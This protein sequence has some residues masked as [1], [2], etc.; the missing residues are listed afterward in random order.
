MRRSCRSLILATTVIFGASF[1]GDGVFSKTEA[2]PF[3][4]IDS[5]ILFVI[6]GFGVD[7]L[8]LLSAYSK[9]VFGHEAALVEMMNDGE[10]GLVN[11][12][13]YDT[14]VTDAAAAAT[15]MATGE[16]TRNGFVGKDPSG[17]DLES[18]LNI[19]IRMKKS[20][21]L[22]TDLSVTGP[23]PAG[24]YANAFSVYDESQMAYLLT[25]KIGINLILGGGMAYFLPKGSHTDRLTD[26]GAAFGGASLRGDKNNLW[27]K[28]GERGCFLVSDSA[29]LG[30]IPKAAP[31]VCGFFAAAELPYHVDREGYAKK[32]LPPTLLELAKTAWMILSR[33]PRGFFFLVEAGLVGYASHENDIGTVLQELIEIDR[34]VQFLKGEVAGQKEKRVLFLVTSTQQ[35]GGPA[36]AYKNSFVPGVTKITPSL[37]YEAPF[38][39]ISVETLKKI[40]AQKASLRAILKNARGDVAKLKNLLKRDTGFDVP[41]DKLKIIFSPSSRVRD[42][43]FFYVYD[44]DVAVVQ[45]ARVLAEYSGV[46]WT[47]GTHLS[48]FVPVAAYG[49]D[50][51]HFRGVMDNTKIGLVVNKGYHGI[52][53]IQ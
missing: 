7:H 29:K 44:E 45:L 49:L 43:P 27:Q 13:S 17:K 30:R 22:V 39:F 38:D 47:A 9:K 18:V 6:E 46:G 11:T 5:A 37:K 32:A 1:F 28:L 33:D 20:V 40:G 35:T 16:K 51:E 50:M 4:K 23:V 52:P 41:S 3:Y 8:T 36:F 12:A 14:L 31:S 26:I 48:T 34:I 42:V 19:A 25:E 10:L 15:A 2:P 53:K 24:F 21:G